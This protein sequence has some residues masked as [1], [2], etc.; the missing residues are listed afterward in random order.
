MDLRR[1]LGADLYDRAKKFAEQKFGN[2][3][4][5][6]LVRIAVVEYLRKEG[7]E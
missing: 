5:A 6:L 1:I 2:R 4:L 3:K 7:V